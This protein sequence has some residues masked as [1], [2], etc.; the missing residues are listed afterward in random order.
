M[1]TLL[2]KFHAF[3]YRVNVGWLYFLFWPFLYYFSRKPGRYI[4]MNKIRTLW[5]FFSSLLSGIIYRFEYEKPIDWSR[6]YIICP[7]HISNLD[8]TSASILTKNDYSFLGKE[9]LLEGIVTRLFFRTVDI[10]VNRLSARSSFRAF[11]KAGDRLKGGANMVIYPEGTISGN[12]PPKVIEFKNGPFRLAIE[13]QVPIIPVTS[14]DT[15][16]VYWDEGLQKGS[17]PG[18]CHIFVH[19]P[20][21][22]TGMTVD[23]ADALRDKVHAII[24]KKFNDGN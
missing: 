24:S 9:E 23:D 3:I 20:V 8:I 1:V 10:P 17:R 14:L 5:G 21:E 19:E 11:K 6:A 15:W 16:K 2:K 12:Y 18:I 7:N 13:H 4:Y 22:T